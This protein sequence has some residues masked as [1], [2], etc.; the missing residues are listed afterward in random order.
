MEFID[1][2]NFGNI[3]QY[4]LKKYMVIL[5]RDIK[6]ETRQ[7]KILYYKMKTTNLNLV[8]TILLLVINKNMSQLLPFFQVN[9]AIMF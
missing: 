7:E 2:K 6:N 5:E 1:H 9:S 8:Y 3:L 4:C